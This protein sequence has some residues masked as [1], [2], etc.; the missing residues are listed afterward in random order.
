MSKN[1]VCERC[2]TQKEKGKKKCY[3]EICQDSIPYKKK[4]EEKKR[5]KRKEQKEKEIHEKKIKKQKEIQERKIKRQNEK[6]LRAPKAGTSVKGRDGSTRHGMVISVSVYNKVEITIEDVQERN[7][8]LN[9]NPNKCFWCKQADKQCGD[10]AHPC[11]NTTFHEYAHTNVLNIFPSC[12]PCNSKKGGKRLIIWIDEYL[13]EMG[14]S[15]Q[16]RDTFK[17]WIINFKDKLLLDEETTKYLERQF[18]D[19][20]NIHA[21]L[22]YCATHKAEVS[23][24]IT[25]TLPKAIQQT[26]ESLE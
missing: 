22:E 21:I 2:G 24:F 15:D 4:Q 8:I 6:L 12:H 13:P 23:D 19:I 17:Q 5:Q 25:Y 3:N 1:R 18:V 14:W 26:S 20:N 11:C 16:E 9:V 7:N 10:H